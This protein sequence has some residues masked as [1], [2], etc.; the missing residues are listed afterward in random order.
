[1]FELLIKT[2]YYTV[3][4][5]ETCHFVADGKTFS[6]AVS[7]VTTTL[8]PK[9]RQYFFTCRPDFKAGLSVVARYF[10]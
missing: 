10:G 6:I 5:K 7:V 3:D 2:A 4:I 8:E 1:M 9:I